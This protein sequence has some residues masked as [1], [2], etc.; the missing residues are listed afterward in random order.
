[1]QYRVALLGCMPI[2]ATGHECNVHLLSCMSLQQ[3]KLSELHIAA[4]IIP[5]HYTCELR[6][7]A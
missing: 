6:L 5:V 2:V 7:I 1:M 3:V 4:I